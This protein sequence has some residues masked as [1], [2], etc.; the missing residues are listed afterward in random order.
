VQPLSPSFGWSLLTWFRYA[1]GQEVRVITML[2][3]ALWLVP[4]GYWAALAPGQRRFRA[5]ALL[6]LV[7]AGLALV[8][9]VAGYQPVHWSEWAAALA[10][11][12]VG[13]AGHLFVP[14]FERRCDSPFIN[15]SC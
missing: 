13:W 6:L 10:G 9:L 11:V 8:P 5:M 7:A 4:V 15:E 3:I 1:Y 2:W 14:Y 12:A